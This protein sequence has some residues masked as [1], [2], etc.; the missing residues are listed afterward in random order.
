MIYILDVIHWQLFTSLAIYS[1][2]CDTLNNN[3]MEL[4]FRTSLL[5]VNL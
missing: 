2:P 3:L 4:G 5:S 1:P